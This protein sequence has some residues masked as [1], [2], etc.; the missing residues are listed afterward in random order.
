MKFVNLYPFIFAFIAVEVVGVSGFLLPNLPSSTVKVQAIDSRFSKLFAQQDHDQDMSNASKKNE[1]SIFN[2]EKDQVINKVS[3]M[4]IGSMLFL[5]TFTGAL[6]FNPENA[7]AASSGRRSGG[8]SFSRPSRPSTRSYSSSPSGTYSGPSRTTINISPGYGYGYGGYGL[9]GFGFGL[10]LF[11]PFGG[12][13]YYGGG[14]GLGIS[15]L[16]VIVLGGLAYGAFN[17]LRNGVASNQWGDIDE[18]DFPSSLGRGVSVVKLQVGLQLYDRS[19]LDQLDRIAANADLSSRSGLSS[20]IHNSALVLLRSSKDWVS[21]SGESKK[22][23][24]SDKGGQSEYNRV[25]IGERAKFEKEVTSTSTDAMYLGNQRVGQTNEPTFAVV[26]LCLAI[27]GSST[28]IPRVRSISDL[29][30]ALSQIAADAVTDEGENVLATEL[31]WT[32]QGS[33]VMTKQDMIQ[34]YP[35]LYDL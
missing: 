16:D 24:A 25:A 10:P 3:Q 23:S 27:R 1:L 22:F 35:E 18:E 28:Q 11:S 21:G 7:E 19:V 8:S 2:I 4:A 20:L 6:G 9:G 30:D 17:F 14:Y 34:D 12:Y 13:G 32:P 29:Q 26:T 15:P 31:L 33:D 5:S